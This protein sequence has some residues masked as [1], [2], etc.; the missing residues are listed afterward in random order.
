M[1]QP[2]GVLVGEGNRVHKTSMADGDALKAL[3]RNSDVTVAL[4]RGGAAKRPNLH[5]GVLQQPK[6]RLAI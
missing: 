4:R 5:H 2:I 1:L 3:R 6:L